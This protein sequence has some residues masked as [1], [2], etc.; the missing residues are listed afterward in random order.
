[1]EVGEDEEDD[2]VK[3]LNNCM[4]SLMFM[5]YRFQCWDLIWL[6]IIEFDLNEIG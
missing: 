5:C 1:M 6:N 3:K 2:E 4:E